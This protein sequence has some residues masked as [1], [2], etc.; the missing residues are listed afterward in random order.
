MRQAIQYKACSRVIWATQ[1]TSG[2]LAVWCVYLGG[3]VAAF[4]PAS[5]EERLV[6]LLVFGLVPAFVFYVSGHILRLVLGASC[7]LCELVAAS[8]LRRLASVAAGCT[9]PLSGCRIMI[10]RWAQRLSHLSRS[11]YFSMQRQPLYKFAFDHSC[12]LIRTTARSIIKAQH[13]VARHR[14]SMRAAFEVRRQFRL[15]DDQR[16][17]HSERSV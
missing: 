1:A 13:L 5:V 10:E 4:V 7:K 2:F 12:F 9:K 17:L 8:L 16:Q 3:A 14:S 11:A 15:T 6:N